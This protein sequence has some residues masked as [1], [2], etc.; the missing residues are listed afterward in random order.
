MDFKKLA[1]ILMIGGAV[2]LAGACIW[3]FAFYSSIMNELANA[4]GGRAAGTSVFDAVSCLYSSSGVC[5]LISGVARMVGKSSYEPMVFWF[6]LAAVVAGGA[7]RVS[8]K[9]GK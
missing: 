3:W 4:P 9:P 2:V 7:I 8:V 1:N 5:S 6:G